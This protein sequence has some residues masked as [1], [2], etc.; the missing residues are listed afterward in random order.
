MRFEEFARD[1]LIVIRLRSC[2]PTLPEEERPE[3]ERYIRDAVSRLRGAPNYW[4]HL[5]AF[6]AKA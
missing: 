4:E 2:L 3:A 6:L 1:M 5:Y